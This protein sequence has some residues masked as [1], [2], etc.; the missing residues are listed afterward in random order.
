MMTSCGVIYT[1][2]RKGKQTMTLHSAGII[3][4][5]NNIST[6]KVTLLDKLH[7]KI[8]CIMH[9]TAMPVGTLLTYNLQLHPTVSLI[10]NASLHHLPLALATH[11][12]LF[13]H[14]ILELIYYFTYIGDNTHKI[15]DLVSFLYSTEQR[16]MT[17]QSK[18]FFLLKLLMSIG[19]IPEHDYAHTKHIV[20]L[21]TID[22]AAFHT[23]S[24]TVQCEKELDR[25]LWSCIW[26]HPYVNE[27]KTVHFLLQNRA[28]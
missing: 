19:T 15:F 1:Y 12:I 26:Q 17:M 5:K 13:L 23:I 10:S 11:D 8:E 24:L 27:F 7:G 14:H 16:A 3:L 4:K 18:K 25:W 21:N 6:H 22:I 28:L 9:R 2:I 20:Y